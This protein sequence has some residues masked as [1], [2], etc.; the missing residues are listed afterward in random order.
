MIS[1][2]LP[3]YQELIIESNF[4]KKLDKYKQDGLL[5]QEQYNTLINALK[6]E[7]NNEWFAKFTTILTN[8]QYKLDPNKKIQLLLLRYLYNV[9]VNIILKPNKN[10]F[11]KIEIT[12]SAPV[13]TTIIR[14]YKN[15]VNKKGVEALPRKEKNILFNHAK[16]LGIN[17]DIL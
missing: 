14:T 5:T 13:L 10:D 6:Y 4:I 17:T 8:E 9:V 16:S 7:P 12:N 3:E 1:S 2:Y 15:Y 11:E